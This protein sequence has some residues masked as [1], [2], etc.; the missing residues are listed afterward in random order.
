VTAVK[1]DRRDNRF[2]HGGRQARRQ[3]LPAAH[4]LAQTQQFGEPQLV[5]D[6]RTD[7][8]R[9]DRAFDLGHLALQIL[10][11]LVVEVFAG[12]GAEDGVAEKFHPFVGAQAVGRRGGVRQG[13]GQQ[14]G[15]LKTVTQDLFGTASNGVAEFRHAANEKSWARAPGE[16]RSR[17]PSQN[18]TRPAGGRWGFEAEPL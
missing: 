1:V 15:I 16:G 6:A 7:L 12:H 17:A 9:D 10:G 8:A 11:E 2:V 5:A 13:L 18:L 14:A 3:F 4:P